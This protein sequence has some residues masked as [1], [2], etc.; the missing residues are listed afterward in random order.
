MTLHTFSQ[1]FRPYIVLHLYVVL[2]YTAIVNADN[3]LHATCVTCE[4]KS[5]PKN[6]AILTLNNCDI[7]ET[8]TQL[9]IT[10]NHVLR[11]HEHN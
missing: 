6:V 2:L 9:L 4:N 5:K 7:V 10:I 1:T 3:L 8:Q 11:C